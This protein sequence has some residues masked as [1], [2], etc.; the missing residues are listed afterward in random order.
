MRLIDRIDDPPAR[1]EH[2]GRADGEQ[3]PA[4][5]AGILLQIMHPAFDRPD[6]ETVDD[7]ER[8]ELGL[9]DEEASKPGPHGEGLRKMRTSG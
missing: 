6:A 3:K 2:R 8:L 9:D 4:T 7:E 1:H 5:I